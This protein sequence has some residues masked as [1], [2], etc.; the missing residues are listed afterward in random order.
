[1]EGLEHH[2]VVLVMSQHSPICIL[3]NSVKVVGRGA[4]PETG[5]SEDGG[6]IAE[7]KD[8]QWRVEGE[9][10]QGTWLL[11]RRGMLRGP[12]G[13][14]NVFLSSIFHSSLSLHTHFS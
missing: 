8:E 11:A 5:T 7:T 6:A 3:E 10:S 13:M 9:R 14:G 4:R 1:M 12:G 2:L